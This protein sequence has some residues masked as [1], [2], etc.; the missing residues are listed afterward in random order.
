MLAARA[1][2]TSSPSGAKA[3]SAKAS[4]SGDAQSSE[5]QSSDAQSREAQPSNENAP[6]RFVLEVDPSAGPLPVELQE[7]TVQ[8]RNQ[9]AQLQWTTASETGNAGFYVETQS[10][11]ADST[12]TESAWT[13]LGFVEG[14]GTTDAPQS[15]QFETGELKY[16][17]HAF[18]LR[19]VDTGGTETTTDPVTVEVQLSQAYAVEAPYP[20]PSRGQ[21]T[22][23]VT[24]SETQRV[25]VILY[26][27][28]GRR[29]ATVHDGEISG[30]DT[31]PIQL[32]TGGLASGTYF[33][34]VRG[35]GFV[36]TE[37]L[38]VVR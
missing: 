32:D 24:V 28:L 29:I 38:T 27:M 25:Q 19:Q 26:D 20:N 37:R 4:A 35:Q 3:S 22:L 12:T 5:A 21:A 31:R 15:Y 23:P 10:L 30:Q 6:P 13:A 9:R 33:V 2:D 14:T 18:R 8:Q 7:L 16:G 1:S 11:S 17:A 36:A 34:R